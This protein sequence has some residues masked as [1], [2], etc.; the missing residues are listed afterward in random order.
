MKQILA[1]PNSPK[2]VEKIATDRAGK[3]FRLV[4]LV[5]IID[6][7]IKGRLVSAEPIDFNEDVAQCVKCLP[8]ECFRPDADTEYISG[9]NEE[10]LSPYNELFFFT[11]QPTRAPNFI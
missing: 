9:I 5:A 1:I 7:E 6:G 8:I 11:S 10:I 2:L 3:Q 4:F